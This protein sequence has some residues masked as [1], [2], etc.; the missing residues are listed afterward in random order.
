MCYNKNCK[1]EITSIIGGEKSTITAEGKVINTP[2]GYRFEYVLDG[3]DCLLS[4]T[5]NEVVQERSGEQNI[6]MTFRKGEQT[7]CFLSSGSFSGTFPIFTEYMEYA[8][9]GS[10]SCSETVQVF[11]L[12]ISYILG[13]QKTEINFSAQYTLEGKK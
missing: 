1:I 5:Y 11:T 10:N 9:G 7:Q 4:V 8:V 13:E 3:D 12:S 6:K 2:S